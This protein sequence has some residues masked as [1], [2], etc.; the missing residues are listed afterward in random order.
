[1]Q[2]SWRGADIIKYLMISCQ[3]NIPGNSDEDGDPFLV[4]VV[5]QPL[6]L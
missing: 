5:K 3:P 6:A 2:S 4:E 1:M